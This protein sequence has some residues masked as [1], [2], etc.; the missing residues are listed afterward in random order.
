MKKEQTRIKEVVFQI[1]IQ[2]QEK[3]TNLS[4]WIV[5]RKTIILKRRKQTSW[6]TTKIA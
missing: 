6:K 3:I 2:F 4:E 5:K 1:V